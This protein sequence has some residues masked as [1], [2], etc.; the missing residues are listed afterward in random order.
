MLGDTVRFVD[1]APP[2]LLVTG[3]LATMLSAFGEHLIGAELE[4][5]VA[6]AAASIGQTV[7]DWTVSA[8]IGTSAS[9]GADGRGGHDY[10]VEFAAPVDREALAVFA[11]TL[12]ADLCARNLDYQAHRAGDFGMD[13]PRVRA[14][15]SGT[16]AAW[17]KSR[18]KLG[19]QNKVPRVMHDKAL[20]GSLNDFPRQS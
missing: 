10:L 13:A 3:R 4:A 6:S 2:R 8:R 14:V 20:I 18:G 5:A 19:G 12:D 11:R 9:V 1:R 17:M 16:F 7:T 15:P